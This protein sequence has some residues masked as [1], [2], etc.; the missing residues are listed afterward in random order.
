MSIESSGGR[1]V[2]ARGW[3]R[4]DLAGGTLDIWPLGLLH[5]GAR[6][7]NIALDLAVTVEMALSPD[8]YRVRQGE[9]VVE[10]R[11]A[12]QLAAIDEAALIGLILDQMQVAPVEVRIESA[13]P[14]MAAAT[15]RW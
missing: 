2:V 1:G 12:S 9:S 3:C 14:R 7:I 4:A 6:T 5:P 13:S 10:A 15:Q 11:T 8:L